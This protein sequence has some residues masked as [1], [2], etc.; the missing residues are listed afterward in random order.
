MKKADINRV[1][2]NLRLNNNLQM[3]CD[4]DAYYITNGWFIFMT[5]NKETFDAIINKNNS[6][7]EHKTPTVNSNLGN[8]AEN[9]MLKNSWYTPVRTQLKMNTNGVEMIEI[10]MRDGKKSYINADFPVRDSTSS[11][12]YTKAKYAPVME[13][14]NGYSI[15]IWPIN[16]PVIKGE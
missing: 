11:L 8:I 12:Y 10:E 16:R 1:V 14:G 15:L 9:C 2:R 7:K 5:K 3:F 6:Y 4:K 13:C